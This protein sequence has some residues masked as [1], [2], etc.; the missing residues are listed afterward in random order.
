M[1]IEVDLRVNTAV[2]LDYMAY[3]LTKQIEEAIQQSRMCQQQQDPLQN[4]L[5][6]I[7]LGVFAMVYC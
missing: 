3:Q 7:M 5:V 1:P 6:A 4:G 2:A